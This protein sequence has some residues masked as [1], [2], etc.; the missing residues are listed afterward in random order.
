MD[1]HF[2]YFA[3]C[4]LTWLIVHEES[5]ARMEV[6]LVPMLDVEKNHSFVAC[7]CAFDQ[8]KS[9]RYTGWTL[10]ILFPGA[11]IVFPGHLKKPKIASGLMEINERAKPPECITWYKHRG[12]PSRFNFFLLLFLHFTSSVQL[13]IQIVARDLDVLGGISKFLQFSYLHRL[14][15]QHFALASR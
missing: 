2:H 11:Y 7:T 4:V 9:S 5:I 15:Q 6:L 14:S 12:Q 1:L 3:I 10:N 13:Q 8:Q